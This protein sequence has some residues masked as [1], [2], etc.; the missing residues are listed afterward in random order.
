MDKSA[1]TRIIESTFDNS[2]EKTRFTNFV[3]NLFNEIEDS[4][5]VYGGGIIPDT[6]KQYINSLERIG[7]YSD[8]ED[9]KIDVLIVNLKKDTSLER[10]RTMQRNFVA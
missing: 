9:N 6:F 7:K 3:R 5:F 2:F 1:A 4:S 10:A 8:D